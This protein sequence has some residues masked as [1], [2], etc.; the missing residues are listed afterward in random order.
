MTT[1]NLS[2]TIT[3]DQKAADMLDA[4][5]LVHNYDPESGLTKVQFLKAAVIAFLREPYAST[6]RRELDQSSTAAI[7]LELA[8]I[9]VT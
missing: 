1:L 4:F 9:S 6:R 3:P 8:A 7:A 2:L 5:C